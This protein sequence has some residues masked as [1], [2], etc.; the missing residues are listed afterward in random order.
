MCIRDRDCVMKETNERL[1]R[2]ET[3]LEHYNQL[4]AEHIKRTNL[5]EEQMQIA[6]LPIKAA[7]LLGSMAAGAVSILGLLKMLGK[8]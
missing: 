2:I 5:L 8:I 7:K 4:L 3:H 1:A 6:L